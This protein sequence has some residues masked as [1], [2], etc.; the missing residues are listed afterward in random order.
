[1]DLLLRWICCA[2]VA[3]LVAME[4]FMGLLRRF[5]KFEDGEI[6]GI[7]SEIP[8]T[9]IEEFS[10]LFFFFFLIFVIKFPKF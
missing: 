2:C 9:N 5:V 8:W 1:M 7:A 6:V 10:L 3:L 4:I